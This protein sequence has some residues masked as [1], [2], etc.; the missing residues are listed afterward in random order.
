MQISAFVEYHHIDLDENLLAFDQFR[1]FNEFFSR[2]LKPGARPCAAPDRPEIVVSPADCRAVV[3][4]TVQAAQQLWIKGREFSVQRLIGPLC[5]QEDVS[6]YINGSLGIFRLAPQDIHRFY[7]PV[8]G[9]LGVPRF[10]EGEYYTL[11]PVAVQTA[12]D[13]YGENVRVVVSI[14]SVKHGRVTMIC[15]G[16]MMVGSI[17]FTR[18]AGETVKRAE[19]LGYF[20]FGESLQFPKEAAPKPFQAAVPSFFSSSQEICTLIRTSSRIRTKGFKLW[21]V[22]HVAILYWKP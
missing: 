8:D 9:V 22:E 1:N 16:G 2:A 14:D 11:N 18:K 4:P 7:V 13:V 5:S 19:E 17:V 6:R 3:F 10:I 21:W 15:I 20:K 12:L